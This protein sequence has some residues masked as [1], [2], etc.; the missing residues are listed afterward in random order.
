MK[1]LI[2]EDDKVCSLAVEKMISRYGSFDTVVNGKEAVD[3]FRQALE[4]DCSYGL[5]LMDI[6]MP[7]VDG[8]QAVRAIRALEASMNVPV[9]HRVKIVMTTALDDPRTIMKALYESD[10]DS[11][12]IKPIRLQKLEEELRALRLIV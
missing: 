3:L 6:M 12:L 1:C 11:Y 7:E 4:S 8:L 10:A 5:V 9:K 2:V